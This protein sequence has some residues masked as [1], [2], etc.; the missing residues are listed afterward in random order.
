[1]IRAYGVGSV[2]WLGTVGL[3]NVRTIAAIPMPAV[4]KVI[5]QNCIGVCVE[6]MMALLRHE[7]ISL[8]TI[9]F[10]A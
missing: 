9:L 3:L 5:D 7:Y 10:A 2:D 4:T 8:V 1:M 6:S